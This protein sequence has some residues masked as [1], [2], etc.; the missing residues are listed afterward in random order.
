MC[1]EFDDNKNLHFHGKV[2]KGGECTIEIP[3][4]EEVGDKVGKLAI[5]VVADSVYFKIYECDVE[6]KNA[7]DIKIKEMA[8]FKEKKVG[9]SGLIQEKNKPVQPEIKIEPKQEPIVEEKKE[10]SKPV[11]RTGLRSFREYS[12]RKPI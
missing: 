8:S 3:K 12:K 4:L 11:K 6:I 9:I 7:V 2:E 1:L 10:E 5:E